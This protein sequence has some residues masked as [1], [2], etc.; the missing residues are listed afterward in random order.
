M[1]GK[2]RYTNEPL[3]NPKAIRDFL[4]S[5]EEPAFRD[6]DVKITI[7]PS[8]ESVEFLRSAA[9][10]S[11]TQYQR[12]IHGL[13][14]VNGQAHAGALTRPSGHARK[15]RA[16]DDTDDRGSSRHGP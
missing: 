8:E 10:K 5:P 2:V 4:P 9:A 15:A 16:P 13:L 1:S 12:M 7:R 14:D 6:E 11:E 3:G